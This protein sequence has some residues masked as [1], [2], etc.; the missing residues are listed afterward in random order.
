MV[1]R[2]GITG[3]V[4]AERRLESGESMDCSGTEERAA[5]IALELLEVRGES[6]GGRAKG[7][8]E[9]WSDSWGGDGMPIGVLI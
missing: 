3:A 9:N 8:G 6:D 4:L 2:G 1:G 7:A 5:N